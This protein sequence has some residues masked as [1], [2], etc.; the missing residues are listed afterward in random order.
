MND[1]QITETHLS[2]AQT[3]ILRSSEALGWD[4]IVVE[5]RYHPAGE[6][7]FPSSSSHLICLHQDS[8][9]RI[10]QVQNGRTFTH[11]MARG[12]LQII[13]AGT[14]SIWRHR[15]GSA[16]MHVILTSALL[17]QVA[18]DYDK[19]HFE[20]LAHF[21]TQDPRIEHISSA[22]LTEVLEG[23]TTG[24]LYAEGLA[25]ALAA[26]L[27]HAYTSTPHALPSIT[28]GLSASQLRNITS[29]IEDRLTE[30]LSLAELASEVGLSSSHF[31]SLFRKSTGLSP[32]H[33]IV[34]RRLE[35]AQHLL[36]ST[37][38]SIGE[39]ASAVGFYDQSHMVRHMRQA[40]GITPTYIREHLA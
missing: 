26:H 10:E 25:H 3:G 31:S 29:L 7:I 14:E 22:L 12:N 33:Y 9:I 1:Q 19:H 16:H 17:Q 39:I 28:R 2:S 5:Q 8:P 21:S 11:I 36:K 4:G 6:Y 40:M 18:A 35:R 15:E 27:I 30:D 13:P 37:R 32:H 38:L 24:R 20:L 23:G 34:Q